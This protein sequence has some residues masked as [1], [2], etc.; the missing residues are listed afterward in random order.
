MNL[1][2]LSP[3]TAGIRRH[4]VTLIAV[5]MLPVLA[6]AWEGMHG[7]LAVVLGSLAAGSLLAWR[8]ARE[9]TGPI[10]RL[11]EEVGQLACSGYARRVPIDGPVEIRALAEDFNA[12]ASTIES[13]RRQLER[14]EQ[15]FRELTEL[16][17]DWYWETGADHRFTFVSAGAERFFGS[18]V[19]ESIGRAR[20]EIDYVGMTAAD[21]ERHRAGL[22]RGKAFEDLRLSRR[23]PSGMVTHFSISGRPVYDAEGD[24]CGYRGVGHDVTAE[25]QGREALRAE[26]DL[27]SRVIETM[28]EGVVIFDAEG[29]YVRMN[30]VAE[31]IFGS[32]RRQFRGRTLREVPVRREP[33]TLGDT[34]LRE[35][36][37]WRLREGGPQ[38]TGKLFYMVRPDRSRVLVSRNATRLEDGNGRFE[39]VVATFEDITDRARSE[40]RNRLFLAS[41]HDGFWVISR[42][43]RIEEV[44]EAMCRLLG[45]ADRELL[46]KRVCDVLQ[47]IDETA[48]LRRIERVVSER[49]LR[50]ESEHLRLDG[51]RTVFEVNATYVDVDGGRIYAFFHD[52]TERKRHEALLVSIARGVST[53]VGEAFFRSLVERLARDLGA[54]YAFVGE[55]AG[56]ASDRLRTLAFVADGEIRPNFEYA[57][58]GTPCVNAIRRRGTV[59]YPSRVADLFPNDADLK[60]LGVEGYVGTSLFGADGRALGILVVMSRK[61]IERGPF[62]A[63]MIKIFGARAGAEIE[64]ARAEVRVL[65]I[66]ESLDQAVRER[67]AQLEDANRELESFNYSI[68][69]DL[70]QPLSAIAGF[71]EIL[72]ENPVLVPEAVREIEANALRME[73]II[74]AL[75]RLSRAARGELRK[76]C[77]D[78]GR[79]V[80]DLV[81]D[82]AHGGLAKVVIGDLPAAR[83][84]T[85]LLRQVWA[86]LIGNA[87]KYSSRNPSP[88]VEISAERRDGALEYVVRDNGVG[89]DISDGARLFEPFR[90]LR[91]AEGF[92]GSGVGLAIAQAIVRRHGGSISAASVVGQGAVFRFTLP[93]IAIA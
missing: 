4:L 54:D 93:Q 17:S 55:V 50:F 72:R 83:G 18:K 27:L 68:S 40:E 12:M 28:A 19:E 49:H 32:S 8:A 43:G 87:L 42:D 80:G 51:E 7:E 85:V 46:G 79:L 63:S 66:N 78:V 59:T 48:M 70:R 73:E 5:S 84:D 92:E 15:R 81:R 75:L 74:D 29:R 10:A 58:Q 89:F 53:E 41:T 31:R 9:L 24:F 13:S 21:W 45:M 91:S 23:A 61:A 56:S 38:E 47:G 26:R 36:V 52:V 39:G 34:E 1:L 20:W 88:R 11:R 71:A 86:N 57:L 69:H 77:V 30:A 35:C 33:F 16:S 22:D 60:K 44:N 25:V 82:L 65:Q 37:F 2:Q 67:T 14:S 62:W 3:P 6:I 76:Q 90:R 64:R